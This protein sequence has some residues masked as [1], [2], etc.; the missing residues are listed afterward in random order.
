MIQITID[1]ANWGRVDDKTLLRVIRNAVN[2][3]IK[4]GFNNG[5]NVWQDHDKRVEL[6]IKVKG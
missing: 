2:Y 4:Y 3:H 6:G 1:I 5:I